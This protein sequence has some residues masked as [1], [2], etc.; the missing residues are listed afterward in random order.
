M[1]GSVV[2][3]QLGQCGNQVGCELFDTLAREA[4]ASSPSVRDEIHEVRARVVSLSLSIEKM[5]TS[6]LAR[7]RRALLLRV[8]PPRSRISPLAL[9]LS[10]SSTARTQAFFRS[11]D[12]AARPSSSSSS[13]SSPTARAVLIDMEPKVIASS[14]KRARRSSH[15]WRYDANSALAFQSGSGNNWARGYNTYGGLVRDEALELV[16][17]EAERCDHLGGFLLTQSL[18]GGTGAGLGAFV[19]EAIR[20]EH[21]GATILNHCVWPYESGEVIVQCYNTLLTLSTLLNVSDGVCVVQNEQLHRACVGALKIKRPTFDDMN[22]VA[23]TQLAGVLLPSVARGVTPAGGAGCGRKLM[24]LHDVSRGACCDPT[25]RLLSLRS[26]PM[27]PQTSVDF[28]TFAWPGLIK[29]ARQMLLT[30]TTLEEG[31]D[32]GVEPGGDG[33]GRVVTRCL[34]AMAFLRG[35]GAEDADVGA[36]SDPRLFPTWTPSP[37]SVSHSGARFCGYDASLTLLSNCQSA[38]PPIGRMLARAYQV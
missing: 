13:S 21:R 8:H 24:L 34:A 9:V 20:D 25:M 19:A 4:A 3:V 35:K 1:P 33:G 10:L 16:R 15:R 27:M 2:T 6:L 31:L 23:A 5:P 30:G 7:G 22:G 11:G 36:L 37:L 38:C 26:V 28:T 17:R 12:G 29:R 32:W 18:A 14:L